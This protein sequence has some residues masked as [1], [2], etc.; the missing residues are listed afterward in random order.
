MANNEAIIEIRAGVGGD[1]AALF[2]STLF[3]MYKRYAL[4]KGW[5]VEI[6]DYN[7]NDLGGYKSIVF[8][9]NGPSVFDKM[10]YESG[11]HRVQRVPKTEK[12]GRVHTST[13]TVAVLPKATEKDIQ[14]RPDEIEVS[15]SRAGGPGGQNV[16]KVETAVRVLHKPTGIVVSSRQ[17]RNQQRNR[18]KAMEILRSKLLEIKRA[19]ETG[20]IT[21]ERRRQIGTG[22]RS[23]KIR[24][25]NFPQDRITDHRI[26][27]NWGNMEKIIN[28]HLDPVIETLSEKLKLP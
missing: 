4:S 16:N 8:E 14:I 6:V 12:S 21:E 9:L 19:E 22:D 17:E 7:Q 1:E 3:G 11:V 5:G 18:D 15:F 24:T 28:G 25:Y 23:E 10:K 2:G 20:S 27:K 26:K 13:A